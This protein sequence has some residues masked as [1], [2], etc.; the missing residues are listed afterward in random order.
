MKKSILRKTVSFGSISISV[1]DDQEPCPG[2]K[3]KLWYN[4]L[5]YVAI[6]EDMKSL[7]SIMDQSSADSCCDSRGLE[8]VDDRI[9]SSETRRRNYVES[10]LSLQS[11]HQDHSL[12]DDRG[13]QR[14][15]ST[16]SKA[17]LQQAQRRASEDSKEAFRLHLEFVPEFL[18]AKTAE[19]YS[20]P[21]RM[22]LG[23]KNRSTP[24]LIS[25]KQEKF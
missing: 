2:T 22:G 1:L 17:D 14:L 24:N 21:T 7:V 4:E 8:L 20:K 23:R 18:R 3:Q 12:F 11:E 9:I 6:K 25:R 19:E 10:I 16:L 13:I 15:A 5:E